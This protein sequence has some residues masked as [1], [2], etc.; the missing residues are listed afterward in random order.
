MDKN[1]VMDMHM[2]LWMWSACHAHTWMDVQ[3]LSC[4]FVAGY[5]VLIM[6]IVFDWAEA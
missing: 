5:T 4:T 2:W 3:C 6:Q 1:T